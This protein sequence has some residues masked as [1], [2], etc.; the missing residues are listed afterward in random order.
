[1]EN[2]ARLMDIECM[3]GR[4]RRLARP[5]RRLN[6]VAVDVVVARAGIVAAE[7]QERRNRQ[8]VGE[9]KAPVGKLPG[10][11]VVFRGGDA[12][13]IEVRVGLRC[14]PEVED[15]VYGKNAVTLAAK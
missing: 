7:I 14:H 2:A 15:A 4:L 5:P 10:G 11:T 3:R 13:V 8:S 1:Q 6:V 12:A 9:P